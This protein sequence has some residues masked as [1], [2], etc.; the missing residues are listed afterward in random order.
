MNIINLLDKLN[1][2]DYDLYGK[3]FAKIDVDYNNKKLGKLILVTSINP[4]PY[5]EGKTTT[6]IGLCDSLNKL[7]VKTIAALREPSMG[8]VFG[9]KGGAIGGGK[10]KI[11]PENKINMNFT[12][13]FHA[14]TYANNLISAVIDNHIYQGNELKIKEVTFN[15]CM[16]VNDRSLRHVIIN[17]KETS[18]VITP[19]SELMSIVGLSETIEDL[20][21]NLGN[22][23][24]GYNEDNNEVY[25][26]D[27]KLVDSLLYVLE[28]AF[29]V[30]L[31][32]TLYNNPVIVHTG[33]FANISYGC[34]SI[35]SIKAAMSLADVTITEAGF[36]S[37][38][39]AVK[40]FDLLSRKGNLKTDAVIIN[41]T[42][43][44]LKYHGNGNLEEGFNNLE[45]HIENMKKFND[46]IIVSL[47]KFEDDN[48]DDINKLR[49]YLNNKNIKLCISTM[50]TDG[51]DGCIELAKEI[52]N[53]KD[54]NKEYSIYNLDDSL[55]DKIEKI[56]EIYGCKDIIMSSEIKTK[57]EEINK[58]HSN[59]PICICKTPYSISD[60]EKLINYP[61]D[62]DMTITDVKVYNGAGYIVLYMGNVLLMP[63]LAKESNYLKDVYYE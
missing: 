16:D 31:V 17:G 26:K 20:R 54:N 38:T 1:I 30:N 8:P 59:L 39:G 62:F 53:L 9:K 5:G 40:Y 46:N 44:A 24:I 10:A 34:S 15:R 57:I 22:I 29:K 4:T 45:Y 43:R 36:G 42:I 33:P 48:I 7:G 60:N 52:I 63:G 19:A 41:A 2:K 32:S 13:D 18:F 37:D 56:K 58:N 47:N 3:N 55:F 50:Y 21:T 11:V 35:K 6:T 12:G 27:L 25:V 61:K 23:I 28:D 51:E 14:I 49:D